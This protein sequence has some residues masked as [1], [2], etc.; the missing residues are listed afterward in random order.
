MG[1][2]CSS[3]IICK[4]NLI[5][6]FRWSYRPYFLKHIVRTINHVTEGS[7]HEPMRAF[8]GLPIYNIFYYVHKYRKVVS[9]RLS[10]LVAHIMIFRRFMKGKF[11]ANVLW[12]LAKKFQN[13]IVDQ[14]TAHDFTV[15]N[16]YVK[17]RVEARVIIQKIKSL[18]VLQTETCH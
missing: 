9:S 7:P 10:R 18:G 17:S 6:L 12:P 5:F 4:G 15:V 11:N 8:S 1:C 14:S 16:I 2:F 3:F 13:W